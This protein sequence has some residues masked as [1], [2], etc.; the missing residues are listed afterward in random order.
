[1]SF[2]NLNASQKKMYL[3]AIYTID[4]LKTQGIV[5]ED[6]DTFH[7]DLSLIDSFDYDTYFNE[8]K[9]H[10]K[11]PRAAKILKHSPNAVRDSSDDV[12]V[13]V[14]NAFYENEDDSHICF[15][16]N[17]V[18]RAAAVGVGASD[19][20]AEAEAEVVDAAAAVTE[21]VTEVAEKPKRKYNRK[22]KADAAEA[23]AAPAETEVVAAAAASNMNSILDELTASLNDMRIELNT[24]STD[25]Q[26]NV[27]TEVAEV[28]AA[29]PAAAE[30]PKRKYNRKPKADAP[31]A[32]APEPVDDM[33]SLTA[34]MNA[35][36]VDTA[37]AP[38][39]ASEKPK[40]KNAK[41]PKV[42]EVVEVSAAA[43]TEVVEVA[44]KPKRKNTKQ[45]K[46]KEVVEVSA[47][48]E[49][50]EV[51]VAEK[52]KRKY[53]KKTAVQ[54]IDESVPEIAAKIVTAAI[55]GGTNEVAAPADAAANN[56]EFQNPTI[57]ICIGSTHEESHSIVRS[58]T[59]ILDN[60]CEEEAYVDDENDENDDNN[61]VCDDDDE[62]EDIV[63]RKVNIRGKDYLIDENNKV[64]DCVTQKTVGKYSSDDVELF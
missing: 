50:A 54:Y 25:I 43:A 31:A 7:V 59:P 51:A 12:V 9:S 5:R 48:A 34:S 46:A 24:I 53:T 21:V 15:D 19:V 45:P 52:P 30:K 28:A 10:F 4:T 20:G 40:R 22:P 18:I 8:Y 37:A 3:F 27:V 60:S 42:K 16:M 63:T 39:A 23:A 61:T 35:M 58:G 62:Y 64:Y 36:N 56:T 33:E 6:F 1:M 41:Q 47:A 29:A 26:T 55:Q 11:K 2:K 38:A 17:N 14:A 13:S 32:A 57:H 44:E 49:V